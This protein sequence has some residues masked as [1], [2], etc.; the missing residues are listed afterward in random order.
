ME[1]D[2]KEK[3][4]KKKEEETRNRDE[5]ENVQVEEERRVDQLYL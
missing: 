3:A 1:R 4:Q 2:Y 5:I